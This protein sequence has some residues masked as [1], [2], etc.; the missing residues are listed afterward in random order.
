M[1]DCDVKLFDSELGLEMTM[2]MLTQEKA[3]RTLTQSGNINHAHKQNTYMSA[4]CM[5][6]DDAHLSSLRY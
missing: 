2:L 4:P 5:H 3:T 6:V 1:Q